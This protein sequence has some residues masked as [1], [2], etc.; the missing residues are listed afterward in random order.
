MP[1]R[2]MMQINWRTRRRT[3]TAFRF[4]TQERPGCRVPGGSTPR[5]RVSTAP[6]TMPKASRKTILSRLVLAAIVDSA[7][8]AIL[9]STSD[10]RICLCNREAE[11]LFGYTR[12]ELLG[13]DIDR[14]VPE[15]RRPAHRAAR[16]RYFAAS[17][18]RHMGSGALPALRKDGT[19][20][21]VEIA[22]TPIRAGNADL[23]VSMAVDASERT[24][25]VAALEHANATLEE[26]VRARTAEL[27]RLNAE[28]A[29]LFCDLETKTKE[30]ERQSREDPLTG[31]SN[32]RDF[33]ER[34]DVEMQR[35]DHSGFPLS[36]A[37]LDIDHFKDV[38][39]RYG[40]AFGDQALCATAALLRQQCRSVDIVCRY[41]GEEF[42]IALPGADCQSAAAAC[43]RVRQAFE[44][45]DWSRIAP[46]L[47]IRVSIGIA[48][49]VPG[50]EARGLL[51]LADAN[52]Y[53]AKRN[54]RNC[55]V[56]SVGE[57]V[58]A[59]GGAGQ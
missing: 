33:F 32:R 35:A 16:S 45:H 1:A 23:V 25:L 30:L 29:R 24:S 50:Q 39:D 31:L 55:V 8:I 53:R 52:L 47:A 51:A 9:A 57:T 43:E 28:N 12:S 56:A 19:T 5:T 13:A 20:V 38:N 17:A 18:M 2:S 4:P 11:K 46:G 58:A 48:E 49:R 44:Q 41:G 54:D 27:E 37:I 21:P 26:R 36:L 34:L 42:A 6:A 59:A 7:P 14:L 22:L 15:L 3:D 40:H 10:G